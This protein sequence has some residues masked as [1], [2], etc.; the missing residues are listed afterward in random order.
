ML[1]RVSPQENLVSQERRKERVLPAKGV[2]AKKERPRRGGRR[3]LP[4]AANACGLSD[5]EADTEVP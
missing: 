4:S 1:S 2:C 3:R 5:D